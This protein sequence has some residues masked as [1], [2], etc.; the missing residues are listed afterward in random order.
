MKLFKT[1]FK[2]QIL[3]CLCSTEGFGFLNN[4]KHRFY[5]NKVHRKHP[6]NI[7]T[8]IINNREN[9]Q[10]FLIAY[11]LYIIVCCTKMCLAEVP[12][13]FNRRV[14]KIEWGT[15]FFHC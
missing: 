15:F 12:E 13:N 11:S 3:N 14:A 4:P 8:I 2:T 5:L 9:L 1:I 7:P 10:H 6:K